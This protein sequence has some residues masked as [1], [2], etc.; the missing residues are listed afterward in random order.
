MIECYDSKCARH[1]TQHG[2]EGPFCYEENCVH[3]TGEPAHDD[4]RINEAVRSDVPRIIKINTS[5]Q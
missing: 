5:K 2:D 3:E 4:A 1:C